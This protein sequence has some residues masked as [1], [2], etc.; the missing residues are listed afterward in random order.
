ME[1]CTEWP[2]ARQT[3]GR[4]EVVSRG[5]DENDSKKARYGEMMKCFR[6][7]DSMQDHESYIGLLRI[8]H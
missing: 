3:F 1:R 6:S 4:N 7:I 5:L 8:A 2:I